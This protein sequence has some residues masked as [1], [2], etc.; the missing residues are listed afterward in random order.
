MQLTDCITPG[1][2]ADLKQA[3]ETTSIDSNAFVCTTYIRTTPE[4][5]WQDLTDPA[6][7]RRCRGVEFETDAGGIPNWS[8]LGGFRDRCLA[9]TSHRAADPELL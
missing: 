5:L 8:Q 9:T 7:T 6:F 4:K 3:L 2:L 1:A